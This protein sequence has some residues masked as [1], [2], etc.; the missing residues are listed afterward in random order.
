[1]Q[2]SSVN[3]TYAPVRWPPRCSSPP[4]GRRPVCGARSPE[5]RSAR[6]RRPARSRSGS[7]HLRPPPRKRHRGSRAGRAHEQRTSRSGRSRVGT[8]TEK[9]GVIAPPRRAVVASRHR[10]VHVQ[11]PVYVALR[12]QLAESVIARGATHR[13]GEVPVTEQSHKRRGQ[14]G[15]ISRGDMEPRR[16]WSTRSAS[17]PVQLATTAVPRIRASPAAFPQGSRQSDGTACTH[18]APSSRSSCWGSTC[19]RNVTLSAIPSDT[20]KR[21][22][23]TRFGPA[24]AM[25]RRAVGTLRTAVAKALMSV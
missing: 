11:Q 24:P 14:R 1:M 10:R 20:A 22:S 4:Q 2:S 7:R 15:S 18:T 5:T 6:P 13:L 12:R 21:S 9:K 17:P 25:R 16:S 8:I 3:A 23:S 19:P